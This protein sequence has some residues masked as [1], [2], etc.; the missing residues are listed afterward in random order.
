MA[1]ARI[2]TDLANVRSELSKFYDATVQHFIAINGVDLGDRMEVQWWF[3][4]YE[5]GEMTV[6]VAPAAYTDVVP[7]IQ[8]IVESAWVQQAEFVDMF[9]VAIEGTAKGLF[10]D[11]DHV[12]GPLRKAAK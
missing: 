9:D 12:G 10:L 1:T 6:F 3:S 5:S 11:K 2:E 4:R 7:S 8:D